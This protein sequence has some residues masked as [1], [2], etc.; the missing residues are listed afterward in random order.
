MVETNR[1]FLLSAYLRDIS[2]T[3]MLPDGEIITLDDIGY[4][5][6]SRYN[7]GVMMHDLWAAG[8]GRVRVLRKDIGILRF[9]YHLSFTGHPAEEPV[10]VEMAV[11]LLPRGTA[12]EQFGSRWRDRIEASA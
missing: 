12:E 9:G 8:V 1:G 10:E 3:L 11:P 5:E 7:L 2:A 6:T 4:S